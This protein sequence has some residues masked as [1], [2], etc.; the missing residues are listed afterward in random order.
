MHKK[1]TE[2]E[3]DAPKWRAELE[4]IL[5]KHGKN[6]VVT[7]YRN[8]ALAFPSRL[9]QISTFD[10]PRIDESALKAWAGEHAWVV[11]TALDMEPGRDQ[12]SPPIRF[13]KI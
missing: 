12:A 9:P 1:Y 8:V 11:R 7:H 13:T 5:A 2:W 3:Q 6:D 10:Y 4:K